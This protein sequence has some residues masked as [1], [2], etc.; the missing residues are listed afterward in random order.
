M[1]KFKVGDKVRTTKKNLS[2]EAG[3]EFTITG[4][5][6]SGGKN[7]YGSTAWYSG[8][9]NRYGIWEDALELVEVTPKAGDRVRLTPKAGGETVVYGEA[10]G[11]HRWM[12]SLYVSVNGE[13][14]LKRSFSSDY[15]NIEV[16]TPPEPTTEDRLNEL[17]ENA[18]VVHPTDDQAFPYWKEETRWISAAT[19]D[20]VTASQVANAIDERGYEIV[21]E[22][23]KDAE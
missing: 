14:P 1:A 20:E 13:S 21:Y 3:L 12:D 8:D 17:G 2:Y 6:E 15:W 9:P 5:V 19:R 18:Y 11:E 4:V 16:I 22:G 23:V 7:S 10:S